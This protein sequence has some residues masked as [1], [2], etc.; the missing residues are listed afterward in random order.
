MRAMTARKIFDHPLLI[1]FSFSYVIG[2]GVYGAA[3]GARETI[4]YVTVIAL[5]M[6]LVVRLHA[7]V[8]LSTNVLWALSLWG[9]LHMAGGL[10][11]SGEGVLY[12]RLMGFEPF[13]YDRLVHAFGFGTGTV[14]AWQALRGFVRADRALTV[15]LGVLVWLCGMGVGA[16]NEVLEFFATKVAAGA[17]VGGYDNT[18]WDLVFNSLGAGIAAIVTIRSA[19]ASSANS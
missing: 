4:V 10:I 5:A 14:T 11:P 9:A 1:A 17:N 16:F 2:F 12:N 15:G 6:L 18:G 8:G 13:H 3:T 7:R 19:R